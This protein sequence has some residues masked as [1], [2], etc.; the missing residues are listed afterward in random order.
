MGPFGTARASR[1]FIEREFGVSYSPRQVGRLLAA[2]NWSVQRPLR[3][4]RQRNEEKIAHWCTARWP[5]LQ[6][7]PNA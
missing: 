2:M 6:A 1:S 7:K 5:A 4:A 3:R